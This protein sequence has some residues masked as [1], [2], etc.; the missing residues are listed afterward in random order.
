MEDV[1]SEDGVRDCVR[2]ETR[3]E[4][5]IG[6]TGET[7][8]VTVTTCTDPNERKSP[9]LRSVRGTWAAR[10]DLEVDPQVSERDRG[11]R[12][13]QTRGVGGGCVGQLGLE[14]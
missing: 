5:G 7:G 14:T 1:G 13:G 2:C 8:V 3:S 10:D 12:A 6:H 9:K 4:R 11:V